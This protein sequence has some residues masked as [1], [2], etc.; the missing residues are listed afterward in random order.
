MYERYWMVKINTNGFTSLMMV[1]GTEQEMQSYMKSELGHIPGYYGASDKE[2][3]MAKQV[4]MKA[5][6]CP[7]C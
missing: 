4:G 3:A 7:K 2:V 6:L 5:Y 1:Y